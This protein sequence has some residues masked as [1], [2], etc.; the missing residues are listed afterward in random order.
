MGAKDIISKQILQRLALDLATLLLELEIDPERLELL[1]TE[2]PRIE[3]RQADVL[4]RVVDLRSETSFLIHIEVQN[5][6]DPLMPL[7]MLRY[8]TDIRLRY[9][10]EPLRQFLIYIGREPLR[11]AAGIDE[12]D[13][14]Y[15]YALLDMHAVDGDALLRRDTPDALVLAILCDFGDRPMQA[16][17]DHVIRRLRELLADDEKGFRDY[18][19]MLEILSENRDL[20]SQM[21]EAQKVITQIQIE[22]LPSFELGLER[23][24]AQGMEKGME[25]GVEKGVEAGT[26]QIVRKLLRHLSAAQVAEM[27]QLPLEKV[28]CI[29]DS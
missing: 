3:T 12:P 14:R 28:L 7:R 20:Q 2:Q 22:K 19:S 6:N 8:Y 10:L 17:V 16:V 24:L 27:T 1:S 5:Q 4:A 21:K 29:R 25:K 26:T 15:R 18:L 11:M 23:G 13:H 9:P